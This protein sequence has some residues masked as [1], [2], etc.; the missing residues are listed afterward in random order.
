LRKILFIDEH[1]LDDFGISRDM[2]RT[3]FCAR[4]DMYVLHG[5]RVMDKQAWGWLDGLTF[6][7][8]LEAEK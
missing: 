2:L 8:F 1:N 6:G 7:A 5:R 3:T 4:H